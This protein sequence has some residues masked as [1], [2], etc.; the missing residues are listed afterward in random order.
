[1]PGIGRIGGRAGHQ[2]RQH[3]LAGR[4]AVRG[5][6]LLHGRVAVEVE[7]RGPR[8]ERDLFLLAQVDHRLRAPVARVVAVLDRDDRGDRLRG[9]QLGLVDVAD[10]D[11][12]DLPLGLQLDERAE[13]VLERHLRVGPVELVERDLLEPEALQAAVARVAQVLGAPVRRP[14][15]RA[16]PLEPALGRDHEILG[17]RRERLGDERLADIRTVGVGGVDE[18]HAALDRAPEHRLRGV[19]VRGL[20]PDPC[21]GDAHR[22]EAEPVDGEVTADIDRAGRAGSVVSHSSP[23][24]CGAR[25]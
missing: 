16:G 3:D 8:Q 22:A 1:M 10:P 25:P 20:A 19:P 13:R 7:D 18:V 5:R 23:L 11:V 4:G 17:V 6:D 21:P 14:P 24:S 12:A 9:A 15:V 2:P